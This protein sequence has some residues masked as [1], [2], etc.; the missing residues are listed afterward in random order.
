VKIDFSAVLKDLKSEEIKTDEGTLTLER[1]AV[2]SLLQPVKDE[3]GDSK[4]T[5]YKL[6]KR[7]HGATEPVELT[8][9]EVSQVKKAIGESAFTAIV[10]GQAWDLIEGK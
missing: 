4:Y 1:V 9:E 10:T 6:I 7:I 2:S 8:A 5:K 3:T